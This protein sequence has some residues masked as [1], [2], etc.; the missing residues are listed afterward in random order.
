MADESIR[1]EKGRFKP[2]Y[3]GGPGR[4]NKKREEAYLNAI[5][6]VLTPEQVAVMVKDL[7]GSTSWRAQAFAA[8][9]VMHYALG[10]PVQR[11]HQTG[12]GL[13]DVLA[14]LNDKS[15]G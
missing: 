3:S 1:D 5:L 8:E 12:N 6:D 15:D 10:K 14:M 9:L 4:P 11:V 13:A 7:A 2:G